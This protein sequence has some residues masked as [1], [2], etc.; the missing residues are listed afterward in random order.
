MYTFYSFELPNITRLR[1]LYKHK[2]FYYYF[3]QNWYVIKIISDISCQLFHGSFFSIFDDNLAS[4][5]L[6][7]PRASHHVLSI[8]TICTLESNNEF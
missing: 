4:A 6:N 3:Q 2:N 8:H 1:S 7:L 5:F